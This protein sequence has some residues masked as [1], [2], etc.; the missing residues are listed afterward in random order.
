MRPRHAVWTL[1]FHAGLLALASTKFSIV[2]WIWGS[3]PWS[4]NY[5]QYSY[6]NGWGYPYQ[7]DYSLAVVV[8]Y[9]AAY[10]VGMAGYGLAW[11]YVRGGWEVL[12]IIL[13]V[14]G[15][16]S[17]LIE[18]SHWLWSHHLSWIFVCPAASLLLAGVVIFRLGKVRGEAANERDR[19]DGGIPRPLHAERARPAAPHH[20]C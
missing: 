11:H 10:L 6:R 3:W 1:G 19:G 17:F 16:V 2:S 7:S 14:L 18:G 12:G 4:W 9:I 8:A 5:F 13:S 20:E 15:L